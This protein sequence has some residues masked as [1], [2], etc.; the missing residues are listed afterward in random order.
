MVVGGQMSLGGTSKYVKHLTS[1][2]AAFE[3][4]VVRDGH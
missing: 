3:G 4:A 1:Y 2:T